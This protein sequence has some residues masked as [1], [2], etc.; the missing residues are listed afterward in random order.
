M[1]KLQI[2]AVWSQNVVDNLRI[3]IVPG[4]RLVSFL[5]HHCPNAPCSHFT[6]PARI[7]LAISATT[8]H[9]GPT[10]QVRLCPSQTYEYKG[11]APANDADKGGV[12]EVDASIEV[13]QCRVVPENMNANCTINTQPY[14][15]T[16][17]S[18]MVLPLTSS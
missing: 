3:G 2:M 18:L 14:G 4:R 13:Y 15:P 12:L 16:T 1:I 5:I 9:Q 17:G 6:L 7:W 8:M 10:T 11:T